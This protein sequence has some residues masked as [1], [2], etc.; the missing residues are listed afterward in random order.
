MRVAVTQLEVRV[1]VV[2]GVL[3]NRVQIVWIAIGS[4][5]GVEEACGI[6]ARMIRA[7]EG[8][9]I[10]ETTENMMSRRPI[11]KELIVLPTDP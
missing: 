6:V 4:Q 3:G 8:H 11:V 5:I 1:I 2:T 9:M 7:A 10:L